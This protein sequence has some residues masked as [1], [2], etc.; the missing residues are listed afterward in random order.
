[1][2]GT[3]SDLDRGQAAIG[4]HLDG[5]SDT[6][7]K[8]LLAGSLRVVL[9]ANPLDFFQP[10]KDIGGIQ[11]STRRDGGQ[12]SDPGPLGVGLAAFIEHGA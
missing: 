6:A 12:G 11:R 3:L 9:V 2:A 4:P 7:R 5:Q 8:P 1:M 10:V